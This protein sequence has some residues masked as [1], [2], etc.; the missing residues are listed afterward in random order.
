MTDPKVSVV[1]PVY[2]TAQYLKQC[3]DSVLGQS[4]RNIEVICIDDGSTDSSL[5][6]LYEY[7][8]KDSRV[9]VIA[10]ENTG[11]GAAHARNVGISHAKGEYLSI[12][13]SD[14]FFDL[15]MLQQMVNRADENASDIVLCDAYHYDCGTGKAIEPSDILNKQ[16]LPDKNGFSRNDCAS[17]IFQITIGAAWNMLFRRDFVIKNNL[18]FQ[19]VHHADDLLFANLALAKAERISIVDKRFIY[20]RLNNQTSQRET[21]TNWP[22]GA[23]KACF[24]LKN[25]LINKGI[26][27]DVKRSFVNKCLTYHLWYLD[28]MKSRESFRFLWVNLRDK[29]FTDLDISGHDKEYFH[30]DY[31]YNMYELILNKDPEDWVYDNYYSMKNK[32]TTPKHLFPDNSVPKSSRVVIYGA[33]AVG[34]AYFTQLLHSRY[35]QVVLWVDKQ[36]ASIGFPVSEVSKIPEVQY[37]FVLIAILKKEMADEIKNEL[38]KLGVS[39]NQIV[40]PFA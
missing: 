24:A 20:Y 33:G 19:A 21:K 12:L 4:L 16:Y 5:K 13:D 8:E 9:I 7:K 36:W 38:L 2:N 23:Y 15:T 18:E 11:A 3:L 32:K 30:Q 10:Q 31:A 37:D 40:Y 17:F 25:A 1:I 34:K 39:E 28:T 6:I 35:C 26:Y 27:E 22:D 29:Y 14:D